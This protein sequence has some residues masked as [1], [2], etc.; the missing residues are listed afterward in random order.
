MVEL[1]S[2]SYDLV[3]PLVRASGMRGHLA[4][5]Y[6]VLDGRVAGQVFA[7]DPANPRSAMAY[8]SNG[9]SFA[10][11]RPDETLARP[12]VEHF[13]GIGQGALFGSEPAWDGLL[14][15][16]CAP[17]GARPEARLAFEL[18]GQ[19]PHWDVPEGFSLQP[20]TARLAESILDGSGTAG[21]GINPWF[22]QV[23]GGP[24]GY[25]AAGLGMALTIG[26][27]IASLCGYCGLGYGETEM[28]VGTLEAYRGRGLASIACAAFM[29]QC[30]ARGLRPAYTCSSDN[31]PSKAV[32]H[33]LGY[34]E[35][36]EVRGYILYH[37]EDE[38]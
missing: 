14:E 7:D 20:I 23:A 35:V 11:G 33:K 30:R 29:E 8:N 5:V 28:E 24:Q 22:V 27:Q 37:H 4:L 19:T 3:K 18:H 25:A 9:F 38:G 1:S 21:F 31:L 34:V 15:R 10:F 12:V 16:L 26:D 36:E 6:E 17:L 2:S 32:A 13:W